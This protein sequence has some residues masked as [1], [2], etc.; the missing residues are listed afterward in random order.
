MFC[1]VGVQRDPKSK[2]HLSA[3]D[4]PD[5]TLPTFVE[6]AGYVLTRD[7]FVALAAGAASSSRASLDFKFEDVALGIWI[8]HLNEN[9]HSIQIVADDRFRKQGCQERDLISHH[10]TPDQMVCM[11]ETMKCCPST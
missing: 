10:L 4:F 7:V 6:G 1:R 2:W 8:D 11:N 3:T 9:G 5:D